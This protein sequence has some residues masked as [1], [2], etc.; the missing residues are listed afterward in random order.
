MWTPRQDRR[1]SSQ[2]PCPVIPD[3]PVLFFLDDLYAAD[4]FDSCRLSLSHPRPDFLFVLW[5]NQNAARL[6][7]SASSGIHVVSRSGV[8]HET[9]FHPELAQHLLPPFKTSKNSLLAYPQC[10]LCYAQAEFHHFASTYLCLKFDVG[11][12]WTFR[13]SLS[14][15]ENL[16]WCSMLNTERSRLASD[17]KPS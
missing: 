1:P 14:P 11:P 2:H 12:S 8:C 7:P 5:R 9:W 4:S 16:N 13:P 6:F 15:N 10:R 17:C 3:H